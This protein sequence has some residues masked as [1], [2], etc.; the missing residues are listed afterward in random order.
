[1]RIF[2]SHSSQLYGAERGL[3]ELVK[4]IAAAAFAHDF[5]GDIYERIHVRPPPRI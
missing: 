5:R 3:Y 4:G 1:M 2:V